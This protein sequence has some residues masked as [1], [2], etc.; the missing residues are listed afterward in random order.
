MMTFIFPFR[1][2]PTNN[3]PVINVQPNFI[4]PPPIPP[5]GNNK[6]RQALMNMS[7]NTVKMKEEMERQ[8]DNVHKSYQATHANI[9]KLDIA[10]R[11]LVD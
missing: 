5:S 7:H 1:A 11:C 3:T 10:N 4:K 2:K 8:T 9:Q 6:T